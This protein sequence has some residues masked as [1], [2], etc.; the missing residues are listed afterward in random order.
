[1][2]ILS[3]KKALIIATMGSMAL[4]PQVAM[5]TE[6]YFAHGWGARHSALGGAGVASVTDASGQAINP[7]GLVGIEGNQLNIGLAI[8]NPNRQ[9]TGSGGPGI[10]PD[11]TTESDSNFFPV[12]NIAYNSRIDDNSAW[13]ISMYGNGGMNTDYPAVSGG[14]MCPLPEAGVFCGGPAGVDMMQAFISVGYSVKVDNIAYGIAPTFVAQTFEGKGVGFFAGNADF[15]FP[16]FTSDATA[17]SDNG[18]DVSTGIG[19]KLGILIDM[20]EGL[21]LGVNFQPKINMSEFDDYAG[22]F[23]DHGD[24]DIPSNWA[25]GIAYEASEDMT[26]MFDYKRINYTDIGSVSND[27]SLMDFQF[28]PITGEVSNLLGSAGGPGFGWDDVSA[29][30]FGLEWKSTDDITWRVGY[31]HNN[32]PIGKN[33][34]NLNILAPGVITTHYTAGFK[35]DMQDNALE[36]FL[37]YMPNEAVSGDGMMNDV[38]DFMASQQFGMEIDV[39]DQIV[40]IEMDQLMVGVSWT[41][42]FGD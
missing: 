35:M 7:A 6:G 13:G 24:F 21:T 9:F 26:F 16:S 25:I 36:F 1:M 19:V 40:T 37:A 42:T 32:N 10:A 31:A 17:L 29:V 22:L 20:A 3:R 4:L 38:F 8:F 12:P 2:N 27:G 39:E 18:H 28:N 23:A 5:A 11:G 30:K 34:V 41:M 15:G 14:G 33:D